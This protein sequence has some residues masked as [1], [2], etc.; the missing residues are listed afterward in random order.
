MSNRLGRAGSVV[1]LALLSAAGCAVD[2][3]KEVDLYRRELDGPT[4]PPPVVLNAGEAL[5]LARA[6]ALANQNNETLAIS[7][8]GYV[9][10]LIDKVRAA[11]GFLPTVS[12]SASHSISR[13][14][15][16]SGQERTGH[17]TGATLRGSVSILDLKNF[18]DVKRAAAT[19]EQQR[20]L[21]LNLQETV[22]LSVATTYYQVLRSER[23]VQVLESSLKLQSERVRDMQ[24]R[25]TLGI[26]KPLDLAQAQANESGTRVQLYQARSNVRNARA[27]LAFLIGVPGVDG[28][29]DDHFQPP[30]PAAQPAEYERRAEMQRRDLLAT[31]SGVEAAGH[32]VDTAVR[33]YYPTFSLDVSQALY[34]NPDAGLLRSAV[35]SAALPIFSAGL[36]HAD[37]RAAWSRYRQSVLNQAQTRRQVHEDIEIAYENLRASREQLKELRTTVSAAQ[38][39]YDLA[40]AT[41]RLGSASNLDQLTALDALRNAQLA[42]ANEEFNEKVFYLDLLRATGEFGPGTP[43]HLTPPAPPNQPGPP[44]P[45]PAAADQPSNG[46]GGS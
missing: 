36:I 24:A 11:S 19:A 30:E 34:R 21:L 2:Q 33:E 37:V 9:Q 31:A 25:Q 6:M 15:S 20:L 22:L 1:L 46:P 23:S 29:L 43:D 28:P 42:Q 32:S 16:L 8:E 44:M 4:P 14:D 12:A 18:S 38:R 35:I 5:T 27:T 13:S 26:N 7:G 3:K 45:A 17:S 41:Y 10:S 39:A 40:T